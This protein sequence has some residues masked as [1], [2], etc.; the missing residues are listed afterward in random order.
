MATS[1]GRASA[2]RAD[3]VLIWC[4]IGLVLG[5][6]IALALPGEKTAADVALNGN[7]IA[8]PNP[9]MTPDEVV[10]LQ[11]IAL[12]AFRDNDAALLQCF[13]LASPLNRAATGS[14]PRFA[15]MVCN[16]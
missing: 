5:V 14:L 6:A 1:S 13:V 12:R 4:I 8:L 10:P 3:L 9:R 16:P 11:L 2:V 15:A 7:G